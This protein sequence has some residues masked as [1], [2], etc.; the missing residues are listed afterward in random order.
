MDAHLPDD[1]AAMLAARD[2][3]PGALQLE[4]TEEFLLIDRDRAW[5]ILTE[6]R[7]HGVQI[8]VSDSGTGYGSLSYLRDLPIDEL[9][10][11]QSF[12]SPMADDIQAATRVAATIG[13]AHSLELRMVAEGVETNLAYAMLRRLG[14]DQAQGYFVSRPVTGA[15]LD[16]WL[17]TW[18]AANEHLPA[19]S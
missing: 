3:P 2:L 11:D 5:D 6:L 1:V 8:A 15:E 13:M 9:K 14:C 16:T 7:A 10:L 12:I 17:G 4:I 19:R 18:R